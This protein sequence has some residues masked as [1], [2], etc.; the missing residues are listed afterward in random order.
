MGDGSRE[1][2]K[3]ITISSNDS[4]PERSKT[5]FNEAFTVIALTDPEKLCEENREARA[6]RDGKKTD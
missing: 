3:V 2:A 6:G 4:E 5:I 1:D